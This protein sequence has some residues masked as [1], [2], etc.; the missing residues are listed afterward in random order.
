[1]Y[2][3]NYDIINKSSKNIIENNDDNY[4]DINT[5]LEDIDN[6]LSTIEDLINVR[7][8]IFFK[9][10]N[11][12]YS[13]QNK[14]NEIT[15]MNNQSIIHKINQYDE[16][17]EEPMMN[18]FNNVYNSLET[19]LSPS[20]QSKIDELNNKCFKKHTKTNEK[21]MFYMSSINKNELLTQNQNLSRTSTDSESK[22]PFTSYNYNIKNLNNNFSES[23]H[24]SK[25]KKF[26]L[27]KTEKTEEILE[28]LSNVDN[29]KSLNKKSNFQIVK[30]NISLDNH[31]NLEEFLNLLPNNNLKAFFSKNL[32]NMTPDSII[33]EM[34]SDV[35]KPCKF[36]INTNKFED[37]MKILNET[38]LIK[39][40]SFNKLNEL[41]K[42]QNLTTLHK[43]PSNSENNFNT[44]KT[45]TEKTE[46]ENT[47]PYDNT[48]NFRNIEQKLNKIIE[49]N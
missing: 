23:S 26:K 20:P 18:K 21:D 38:N 10:V 48:F 49:I 29:N 31:S 47:T 22:K 32:N 30:D 14:V 19:S 27:S 36:E 15:K 9:K 8:E 34:N 7:M 17:N 33:L 13:M 39:N 37:A 11:D 16:E 24:S 45:E 6:K 25:N 5:K 28:Q 40:N 12:I 42:K 4:E 46:T 2:N 3:Y 43:E 41:N 35:V 44:E 1:M